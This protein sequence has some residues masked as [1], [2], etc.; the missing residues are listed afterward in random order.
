MAR[1]THEVNKA[2]RRA[3]CTSCSSR[4]YGL[5]TCVELL[6]TA[7]CLAVVFVIV[8]PP[9]L[10]AGAMPLLLLILFASAATTVPLQLPI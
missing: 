6:C 2:T 9:P 7:I 3:G 5:V 4:I 10:V 8:V 1:F